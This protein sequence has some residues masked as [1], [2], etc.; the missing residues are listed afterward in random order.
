MKCFQA[1]S[2]LK[3][4]LPGPYL[5]LHVSLSFPLSPPLFFHPNHCSVQLVLVVFHQGPGPCFSLSLSVVRYF[6]HYLA[7]FLVHFQ[8][9]K[10]YDLTWLK[11]PSLLEWIKSSRY[12]WYHD[13]CYNKPSWMDSRETVNFVSRE[14]Q[15]SRFEG[16]KITFYWVTSFSK[17]LL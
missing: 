14:S 12:S 10:V 1:V 8:H 16:N 13:R 5:F 3:H 15:T 4:T 11:S 2:I 9:Q 6:S 17:C 7:H